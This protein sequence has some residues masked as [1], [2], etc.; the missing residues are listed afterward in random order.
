MRTFVLLT[1]G[2]LGWLIAL[3]QLPFL[4]PQNATW[5]NG[6]LWVKVK[7]ILPSWAA[8]QCYGLVTITRWDPLPLKTY[9]HEDRHST[10]WAYL[11]PLFP[12]A[13][14]L[15]SLTAVLCGKHYYYDNA[16][17]KDARNVS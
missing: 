16:F 12:I 13:Y 17:E 6:V 8:A 9:F 11:G 14:G 15:A 2:C 10:Q 5:R 1:W 3:L 4:G 7:R